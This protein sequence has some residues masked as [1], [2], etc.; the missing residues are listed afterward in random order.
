MFLADILGRNVAFRPD[1]TPPGARPAVALEHGSKK[2][3]PGRSQVARPGQEPLSEDREAYQFTTKTSRRFCAQASS[4]EP[5]TAG[6]SL[7]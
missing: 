6:R 2:A 5:S 1:A 7:P 4:L 3:L